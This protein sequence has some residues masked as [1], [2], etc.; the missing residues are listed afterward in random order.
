[1]RRAR[2]ITLSP[3]AS[4]FY[5]VP[6]SLFHTLIYKHIILYRKTLGEVFAECD[7]R[8]ISLGKLYIDQQWLLCRVLFVGQDFY[9]RNSVFCRVLGALPNTFCRAL[10]KEI[11]ATLGKVRLS[12]M[13]TFTESMTLSIGRHS[14]TTTLSSVKH[15]VNND[16][17]QRATSS[18]I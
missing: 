10:D 7:T 11:F 3:A 13:N 16:A 5:V 17:R 4:H 18:R 6:H 1:L 15:S 2:I 12:A 8:Q 9:Y 14:A